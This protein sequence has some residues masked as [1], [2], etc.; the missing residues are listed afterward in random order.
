M[1]VGGFDPVKKTKTNCTSSK[2]WFYAFDFLAID[3]TSLSIL[4]GSSLQ[5]L[6]SIKHCHMVVYMN[7]GAICYF[8]IISTAFIVYPSLDF[9]LSMK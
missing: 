8:L 4:T 1:S 7:D 6:Y 3:L 2:G 9:N 5:K